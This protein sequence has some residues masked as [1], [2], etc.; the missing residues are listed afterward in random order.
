M[1]FETQ[2]DFV[3]EQNRPGVNLTF[4]VYCSGHPQERAR[5]AVPRFPHL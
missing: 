3:L 2:S 1:I 4:S 5:L